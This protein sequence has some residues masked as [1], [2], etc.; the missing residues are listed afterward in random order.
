ML[1]ILVP[2][3]A[4][5][6]AIA[7]IITFYFRR[8]QRRD[9]M[10]A[11]AALNAGVLAVT[12]MLA[13]APVGAGLG[14]GLFGVLSIIRLRSD[15]ITQA[16]IAYYFIAL[17]LGLITGI[18]AGPIWVAP[19]LAAVLVGVMFV[20]DH[21]RTLDATRRQVVTFD[22]AIADEDRLRARLEHQLNAD[23]RRLIIEQTDYVRDLTVV[24]VRYRRRTT[25]T[26]QNQRQGSDLSGLVPQPEPELAELR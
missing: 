15:S 5:F 23:V 20:V 1:S 17:A 10:L 12:T 16:E 25:T 6:I 19:A 14:L 9:L 21:P 7:C 4:D 26:R 13:S 24:D 2:L 8:H 3:L 11:Y 18:H 22:E